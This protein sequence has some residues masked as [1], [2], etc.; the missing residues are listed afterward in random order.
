MSSTDIVR[1]FRAALDSV[2]RTGESIRIERHGEI[3]AELSPLVFSQPRPNSSVLADLVRDLLP[4][5]EFADILERIH[6]EGNRQDALDPWEADAGDQARDDSASG[7][8]GS[9]PRF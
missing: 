3:V 9:L 4:D 8:G 7:A 1:H 2:I 6:N 5:P